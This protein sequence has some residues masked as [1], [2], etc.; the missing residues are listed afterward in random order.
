[1]RERYSGIQYQPVD[2]EEY[3]NNEDYEEYDEDSEAN[4]LHKRNPHKAK[5]D[6]FDCT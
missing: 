2:D 5:A 6:D 4:T 1:M 3:G